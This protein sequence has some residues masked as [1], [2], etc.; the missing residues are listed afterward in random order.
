ML[1]LVNDGLKKGDVIMM[2]LLNCSEFVLPICA[3]HK[4]HTVSCPVNYRLS[5]GS[6]DSWLQLIWSR[7]KIL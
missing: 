1:A 2:Q 4:T 5:S 3:A 7:M 6:E